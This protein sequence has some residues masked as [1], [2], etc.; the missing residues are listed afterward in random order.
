MKSIQIRRA[1]DTDNVLLAELGARCFSDSFG[2]YNTPE[3]MSAYLSAS[4]SPEKQAA[5][6]AEPGS[7][8]LIAEDG[9]APA[10]YARLKEG[11]PMGSPSGSRCIEIVR[12]Y[13]VKEWIGR[14]VGAALM[15]AC[16]EEASRRGCDLIW[17][18]VWE[19]NHRAI[20]FYRKWGFTTAGEQSFQLGSDLQ[21]D[22]IMQR[23]L[24]EEKL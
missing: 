18:D 7:V 20:A 19:Q 9:E 14:G 8:F 11:C 21:R 6:L 22:L 13:A 3:D 15:I 10:G 12:F 17:L 2:A 24:S 16:L 1:S 4:F 23:P 5:E